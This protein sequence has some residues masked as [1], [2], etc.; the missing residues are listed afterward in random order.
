MKPKLP[1]L[2]LWENRP[3]NILLRRRLNKEIYDIWVEQYN[4]TEY[5]ITYGSR[6]L[7]EA[8]YQCTKAV[9]ENSANIDIDQLELDIKA[10]VGLR[11][12]ARDVVRMM[13]AILISRENNTKEIEEY[14]SHFDL[15]LIE[16][17]QRYKDFLKKARVREGKELINLNPKPCSVN[18]L[19]RY[20]ID[21]SEVTRNFDEEA[22][23][24]VVGLWG[25]MEDKLKVIDLIE[26]SYSLWTK[27]HRVLKYSLNENGVEKK[28]FK[29]D[30]HNLKEEI[31]RSGNIILEENFHYVH[32]TPRNDIKEKDE[33][34]MRLKAINASLQSTIETLKSEQNNKK[35]KKK[36]E[37]SFTLSMILDYTEN[38]TTNVTGPIL[39]AMLNKFLRDAG[40]STPEERDMVDKVENKILH[41]DHGDNVQ[42]NK[43]SFGDYSSMLNFNIGENTDLTKLIPLLPKL[44][45]QL[46]L[47]QDNG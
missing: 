39:I 42:G 22:I 12:M 28:E 3:L 6:L 32:Y 20:G 16:N 29:L 17:S 15:F 34:I 27:T 1:K 14:V 21:W 33:E 19:S 31:R 45:E 30:L 41:P 25:R 26:E 35:D 4:G 24:I 46:K 8:Y 11:I 9:F 2:L 36:Q 5:G 10:N 23:R 37:R 40:N 38:H 43:S 13:Y 7:N 47:E 18:R 44:M